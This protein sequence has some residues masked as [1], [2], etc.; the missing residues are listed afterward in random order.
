[1][2]NCSI[3]INSAGYISVYKNG[4]WYNLHKLVYE[5]LNGKTG[6]TIHHNDKDKLNNNPDNLV[7][8]SKSRHNDLHKT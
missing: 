6:K 5:M 3:Y 2:E 4:K 7:G 8:I 1:M